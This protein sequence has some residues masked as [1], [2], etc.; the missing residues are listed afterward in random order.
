MIK[1]YNNKNTIRQS[2]M[3]DAYDPI[4][5]KDLYAKRIFTNAHNLV[6]LNF[7]YYSTTMSYTKLSEVKLITI[8][9]ASPQKIRQWTEK[10]LP[11]GKVI[12]KVTNANT[13][14][15]KTFKP[16]KGGLF[17]DRIFG[18]LKDFTCA[19][20]KVQKPTTS[21]LL[22]NEALPNGHGLCRQVL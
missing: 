20:G 13:L 19:C 18:P 17:C 11:N 6:P 2:P 15:H 3:K 7:G 1:S 4:Y 14:H 21:N 8:G 10:T 16:Q 5:A 9:L 22:L 12:G